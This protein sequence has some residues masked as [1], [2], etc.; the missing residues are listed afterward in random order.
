[1]NHYSWLDAY[2]ESLQG[3]KKEYKDE[4]AATRYLVAGK[5]FALQGKDQTGRPI[6]TLKLAPENGVFLRN[7]YQD[8]VAGYYM[9]KTHWN[10]VYL[11]GTVPDE[12]LRDMIG[13]SYAI[14]CKAL[15]KK[16]RVQLLMQDTGAP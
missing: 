5:M 9:N 2:C 13:E 10:S 14:I 8:V 6:V 1:M 12:V 16:D 15:T 7:R 4:W 3:A 11:D